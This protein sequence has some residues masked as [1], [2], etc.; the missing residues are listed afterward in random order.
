MAKLK[1]LKLPKKP[2]ANA[3]LETMRKYV[4]KVKEIRATNEHRHK[5]N[6]EAESMKK[7]IAGIGSTSVLPSSFKSYELRSPNK[8]GPKKHASVSGT[9]KRKTAKKAAPKKRARR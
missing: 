9:A 5:I 2:K 7:V 1:M 8:K 4:A 3:S 6:K